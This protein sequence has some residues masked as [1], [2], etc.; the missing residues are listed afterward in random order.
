MSCHVGSIPSAT[1]SLMFLFP[2][3]PLLTEISL[4][5]QCSVKGWVR[6]HISCQCWVYLFISLKKKA[7]SQGNLPTW[8]WNFLQNLPHQ[9]F[10]CLTR[11]LLLSACFLTLWA[12]SGEA[13]KQWVCPLQAA[14]AS[15]PPFP[16]LA[17]FNNSLDTPICTV[18]KFCEKWK[19]MIS[20]NYGLQWQDGENEAVFLFAL[21]SVETTKLY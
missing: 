14:L 11:N 15:L 7:T 4:C 2:L 13:R 19:S 20:L 5:I 21:C 18:E 3:S 8:A 1:A 12:D 10:P 17:H 16:Q 6:F 9:Y